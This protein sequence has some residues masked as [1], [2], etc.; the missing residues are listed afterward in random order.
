MKILASAA[1][2][3]RHANSGRHS[4][5]ASNTRNNRHWDSGL[6][7]GEHFLATAPEHEGIAALQPDDEPA[8]RRV[9]DEQGIDLLLLHCPAVRDLPGINNQNVRCQLP[10]DIPWP[11]PVGHHHVGFGQQLAAPHREQARVTRAA[12]DEGNA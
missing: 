11:E 5:C 6:E 12:A 8:R 2:R 3:Q 10:E 7:A 4:D 9:L 1:M